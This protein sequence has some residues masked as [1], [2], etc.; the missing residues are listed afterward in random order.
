MLFQKR[1][2]VTD[3]R[4]VSLNSSVTFEIQRDFHL[5]SL[6][7][8]I[9]GSVTTFGTINSEGLLGLIRRINLSV[10]DGNSR[11]VVDVTGRGLLEY[12]SAIG[13]LPDRQ[14]VAALSQNAA[15]AFTIRL[16]IYFAHPQLIDPVR[17]VTLLPT[18]R[19]ASNPILRVDIGSATD[20]GTGFTI[21]STLSVYVVRNMRVVTIP[22]FQFR[23]CELSENIIN[24]S[25]T[26]PQQR[27]EILIPGFTSGLLIRTYT[28]ATTRGNII[29]T[30][31]F[32]S[33]EALGTNFRRLNPLDIAAENDRS[34]SINRFDHSFYFDFLTDT[35]GDSVIEMSSLF[36]G[37]IYAAS[38]G[39]PTIQFDIGAANSQARIV[40]HR[41]FGDLTPFQLV[42]N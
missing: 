26:G 19:Y 11:N 34:L 28:N 33:L 12:N 14:T 31:G 29:S 35:A 10:N 22:A 37:N 32:I 9:S 15:G 18:P 42:K 30:N 40:Q 24:F 17:S 21:A 41:I 16:P 6:E 3:T 39:K 13:M 2:D 1:Q 20:V 36:D 25:A 38:G 4:S 27:Y 5:E 8:V 23:D 7:L